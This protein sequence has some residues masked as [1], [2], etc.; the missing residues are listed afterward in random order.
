MSQQHLLPDQ[1]I[2]PAQPMTIS[3]LDDNL[4]PLSLDLGLRQISD[5][6]IEVDTTV[7]LA[8]ILVESVPQRVNGFELRSSMPLRSCHPRNS[9]Y[10]SN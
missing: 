2:S 3:N 7:Y 8:T 6:P 5:P 9:F 10:P 4:D 1:R